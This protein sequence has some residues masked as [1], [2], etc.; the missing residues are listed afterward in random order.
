MST[1]IKFRRDTN[2][3]W[4]T[5]NPTLAEGEIGIVTDAASDSVTLKIGDGS[6]VWTSLSYFTPGSGGGA[7]WGS[8]T[9]T[10]SDQTDLQTALNAKVTS[11]G[12]LGT[13][14]SGTL[15]NCTGTAAGLTAGNVTTNANLTGDV[16]SIGNAATISNDYKVYTQKTNITSAELLN[17]NSVPK[18]LLA[19]PGSGK[20]YEILGISFRMNFATAAYASNVNL[21]IM[22]TGATQL[23]ASN[24]VA[25][26]C[27]ATRIGK[28][29]LTVFTSTNT[30]YLENTAIQAEIVS[31]NPTAGG[32]TLDLYVTYKI[33]TL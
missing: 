32:G 21:R 10:L 1:R 19:A 23:I 2:A 11:G 30:Q 18:Q 9:G 7:S 4:T 12:A 29:A 15:T 5:N 27:T 20:F 26:T 28:F 3:N 33:V 17:L 8:I 6:T 22:Y 25:I 13:P 14:S 24:A 16:T 31:G